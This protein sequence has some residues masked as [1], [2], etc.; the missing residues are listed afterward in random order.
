MSFKANTIPDKAEIHK[1]CV[2]AWGMV[3]DTLFRTAFIGPLKKHYPQASI[4]VIVDN[5]GKGLFSHH[6]DVDEEY[7]FS[8]KK[9]P[10]WHYLLNMAKIVFWMR[11]KKFDLVINF[12]SGG[13]SPL[14][15]RLSGG[16]WRLG[17][18][19]TAKLRWANNIL[20]PKASFAGHWIKALGE[21][22]R[23]LG[24]NESDIQHR[25]FFYCS[26]DEMEFAK[27]FFK[28]SQQKYVGF[29]LAASD[30]K[31]CWPVKEHVALANWFYQEQG[32]VPLVLTNPGQEFLIEE[33]KRL[34]PQA[35]P[36]Q[37]VPVL[38]F[39]KLAAILKY[40]QFL[41]T[42]D[43]GI[44][45]LAFGAGVPVL[46]LFT[47]TQP[48]HVM[49]EGGTCVACFKPDPTLKDEYGQALGSQLDFKTVQENARSLL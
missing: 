33:F 14:I 7:V 43:T 34:Y 36:V 27:D 12:Y 44:M 24:I 11:R 49:P 38:P 39:G 31:K 32:L 19:H 18:D 9:K 40:S 23:P 20:A 48:Y 45:H 21:T 5:R 42:G 30:V 2:L 13:S 41:V 8:H 28:G 47:Y 16:K 26:K 15:T 10:R 37:Y 46:G 35:Q 22:L 29:N 25:P 1:I 4:S 3:G 17:F 6:P